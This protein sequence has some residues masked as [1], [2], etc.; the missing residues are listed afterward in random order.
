MLLAVFRDDDIKVD[1]ISSLAVPLDTIADSSDIA[2]SFD[3]DDTPVTFRTRPT[4]TKLVSAMLRQRL[5]SQRIAASR[6]PTHRPL[7]AASRHLSTDAPEPSANEKMTASPSVQQN[8]PT[9]L[10][11]ADRPFA[12]IRT[13]E[14]TVPLL[15]SP[16]LEKP[17]AIRRR[18]RSS[19][20]RPDAAESPL[21]SGDLALKVEDHPPVK[22][23]P[24]AS[25]PLPTA[26][27]HLAQNSVEAA[28][29]QLSP[30]NVISLSVALDPSAKLKTETVTSQISPIARNNQTLLEHLKR[31]PSFP[32][33][34]PDAVDVKK[35]RTS[36]PRDSKLPTAAGLGRSSSG[37][38]K[39]CDRSSS[40]LSVTLN[41]P[42]RQPVSVKT[43]ASG[44]GSCLSA[45]A[46]C[47]RAASAKSGVVS[48]RFVSYFF[49]LPIRIFHTFIL[50]G[51]EALLKRSLKVSRMA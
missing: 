30:T 32:G 18:N 45:A 31:P 29:P 34:L 51:Y 38:S 46:G 16:H 41:P 44:S 3:I 24:Q 33:I 14:E 19:V 36:P 27:P 5:M 26:A 35:L 20:T 22:I 10:P 13:S 9:L 15:S 40:S 12:D 25:P 7:A 49:A 4:R 28:P 39:P 23:E 2:A 8:S 21:P 6:L 48:P 43:D 17:P 1:G 11:S 42:S 37:E 50:T 47:G